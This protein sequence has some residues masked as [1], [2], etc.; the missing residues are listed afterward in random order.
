MYVEHEQLQDLNFHLEVDQCSCLQDVDILEDRL[1]KY[2]I[3]Y[4][5]K[6]VTNSSFIWFFFEC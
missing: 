6:E 4:K 2:K 1:S 3:M 5:E